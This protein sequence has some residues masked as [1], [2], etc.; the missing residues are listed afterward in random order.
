[1]MTQADIIIFRKRNLTVVK[2]KEFK[3]NLLGGIYA[4]VLRIVFILNS[5]MK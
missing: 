2:M 5:I 4:H 3:K 1:M